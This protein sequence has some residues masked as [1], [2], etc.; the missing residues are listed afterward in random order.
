MNNS[1]GGAVCLSRNFF[2]YY[3]FLIGMIIADQITKIIVRHT[4]YLHQSF[5]LIGDILKITYIENRGVA[6]SMFQESQNKLVLIVIPVIVMVGLLI[7]HRKAKQKYGGLFSISVMMIVAGG[8]SNLIDRMTFHS[9]TDFI[10]LKWFAIFNLADIFAVV[11]CIFLVI[12]VFFCERT[13]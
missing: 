3:I 13:K 4:M 5:P 1:G 2:M 10:D 9:V 7:Y 8:F 12:S 6:F 11:G